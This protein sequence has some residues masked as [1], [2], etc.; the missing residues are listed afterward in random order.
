ME[1]IKENVTVNKIICKSYE[2]V[3]VDEDIIVPDVKPDILKVLQ[4]DALSHITDKKIEGTNAVISGNTELNILY[5]PDSERDKIKSIST[6]FDF[7]QKVDSHNAPEDT[8]IFVTSNV[9][10]AE[11]SLINS[12]KLRIKAVIGLDCEIVAKQETELAVDTDETDAEVLK[13]NIKLQNCVGM[14]ESEF[15][16]KEEIEI[17]NSRGEICEL[18]KTDVKICNTEYKTVSGKIVSKGD[19]AVCALYTDNDGNIQSVESEFPFTEVFDCEDAGDDTICDIDYSIVS[20]KCTAEEDSDGEKRILAVSVTVSAQIKATESVSLDIISDCFEPR[21]KTSLIKDEVCIDE[22]VTRVSNVNTIRESI[23]PPAGVPGISG[24][25]DVITRP[26]ITKAELQGGK[27]LT[28]GKIEACVLYLTDNTENPVYSIKRDIPISVLLDCDES[29]ENLVP[30]IKAEVK[31]T[32]YNLNAAGEIE[33]RCVLSVGANIINKRSMELINEVVT[34]EKEKT[35]KKGLIIYFVQP[36]DDLWTI[37]KNYAVP[38]DE[39]MDLNGMS[40]TD[41]IEKGSR[42]FIPGI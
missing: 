32:S 5:I 21:K 39:I 36:G 34:E 29:G 17:P 37:S 19:I 33:I 42:L 18:L 40:D 22:I 15:E 26:Y 6:S 35:D 25:Y 16:V 8:A 23:E 13:E 30:E 20:E 24:V 28:E 2:Q 7:T 31:H 4:L 41:K 9:D 38:R 3:M 1:L 27:L 10:R 11:F 12:R 14:T